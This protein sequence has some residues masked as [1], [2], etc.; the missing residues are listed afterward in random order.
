MKIGLESQ[1]F[2][3]GVR[4]KLQNASY[5]QREKDV[6]FFNIINQNKK[7]EAQTFQGPKFVKS[8]LIS[9]YFNKRLSYFIQ[10]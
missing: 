3:L 8:S 7:M 1:I 9:K 5:N 4:Q 10:W 6:F 2:S